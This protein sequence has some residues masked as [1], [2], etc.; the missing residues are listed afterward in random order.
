MT[1]DGKRPSYKC[2]HRPTRPKSKKFTTPIGQAPDISAPPMVKR[3]RQEEQN[4][5][6]ILFPSP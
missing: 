2:P 6:R 1:P 5:S 3:Q 4:V